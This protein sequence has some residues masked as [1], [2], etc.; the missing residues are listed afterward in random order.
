MRPEQQTILIVDDD[1]KILFAFQE[2]FRKDG[3][4]SLVARDGEAALAAVASAR[5]S[6]VFMDVT[7]PNM[8]GLEALQRL[9]E[10]FP[11][12]PIIIITGFSTMQTAIRAMQLGAFEYL[13]KPLDVDAVRA[14]VRRALL[15]VNGHAIPVGEQAYR[16]DIVHRYEIVGKS[17]AML[18]VFKLIGSISTTPNATSVLIQ[19]ESGTGKELVARAIHANSAGADEPFVAI[20]CTV[21]PESLLESELFGHERGA[22]TG[23]AE[24][25]LG[26]FEVAG[27]GTIFL[28]EIGSLSPNLQQKLLRVIQEREFERV[29]GNDP[30]TV[31]ARFIAATNQDLASAVRQKTFREDLF[32]RLNVASVRLPPLRERREDIPLLANYFLSKYNAQLKKSITGFSE[33]AMAVLREYKF[34]GNVRELENLLQRAVMLTKSSIILADEFRE[35]ASSPTPDAASIP[36]VSN[37]MSESRAHVLALFERRFIEEQLA[38]HGGNVS[39][40]AKASRMTR[41]NMQRLMKK[42]RISAGRY[43]R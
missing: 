19:G 29:G 40:A 36:I 42:Y 24:R 34:P 43:R 5:P 20:N 7:M 41:Q 3:L 2:V 35:L 38:R 30:I 28:D 23:A 32:F 26:K 15:G 18:E 10:R 37:V 9:K 8:G 17:Q 14:V 31:N 12:I 27:G 22:F 11:D 16:A 21:L 1:E 6:V 39:A 4:R 25:K 13:T 33:E